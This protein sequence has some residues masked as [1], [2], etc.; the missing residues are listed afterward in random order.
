MNV[1]DI[2]ANIGITAVAIAKKTGKR[3]RLYS[4]DPLPEYSDILLKDFVL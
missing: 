4:F 1:I 3:G 2:G